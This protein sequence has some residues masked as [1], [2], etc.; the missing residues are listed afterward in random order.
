MKIAICGNIG[1]GKS[2][3]ADEIKNRYNYFYWKKTSFAKKVKDLATELF[4]M[5]EKDRTLLIDLATKMREIDSN[6]WI[7]VIMNKIK[8]NSYVIIDDL[9]LTNEYQAIKEKQFDLIIKLD[10]DKDIL[11]NRIKTLYKNDWKVHLD[12]IENS[13]TENEVVK[14]PDDSF[15][16]V[17]KNNDYEKLFDFLDQKFADV[18]RNIPII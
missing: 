4:G 8:V 11:E 10:T 14:M 13:A 3:L 18:W 9:R 16:F 15:D 1:S 5:K 2:S 12:A 6:V 7:N 17:I